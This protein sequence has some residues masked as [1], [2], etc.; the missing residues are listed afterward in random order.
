[1]RFAIVFIVVISFSLVANSA[2]I[3][4]PADYP[5]IQAGID[6]AGNTDTV[7]V[8]PGTYYENINLTGKSII[9][10]S[11]G[12][13]IDGG[14][15]GS[16]VT[17][18][19]NM[20]SVLDGFTITNGIGATHGS[21]NYAG[22]GIYCV[23]SSP[24]IK[25]NIIIG[26]S[27]GPST[28]SNGLG[29]GIYCY[30]SL[31]IITN[32]TIFNNQAAQGGGILCR[33]HI[34]PTIKNNI[35]KS[36]FA[37]YGGG[38]MCVEGC[39]AYIANNLIH[40]NMADP[41]DGGGILCN[42]SKSIIVNNTIYMNWAYEN[43][44]GIYCEAFASPSIMSNTLVWNNAIKHGG[45]I[46]CDYNC[47]ATVNNTILWD[48]YSPQG[49]TICLTNNSTLDIGHSNLEFGKTA[50]AADASSTITWGAG[51]IDKDPL[52]AD[53]SAQDFHLT[54]H[55]PC[56]DSGKNFILI[57]TV[58]FEG[59]P[60]IAFNTIDMGSDEF[61]NHLYYLGEAAPSKEISLKFVGLPGSAPVAL[62]V[63]NG[64]LNPPLPTIWGEWHLDFPLIGPI[65]FSAI[66]NDGIG[67]FTDRLPGNLIPPISIPMQTFI[68]TDLSNLCVLEV[69]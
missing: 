30:D 36:N 52:F 22:G 57:E 24:N 3:N 53:Q 65:H 19:G 17:F 47:L 63:G 68:G 49:D 9:L 14:K 54:F 50:V 59:D 20:P 21:V 31:A 16:V 23:G 27:A 2:T 6:A 67:V 13:T 7:L 25:N 45:G 18:T 33:K 56:K 58:D 8:A 44:G 4:I 48:H 29:G 69:E 26:N 11:N 43:G 15:K 41:Y 5:T 66:P 40:G 62:F 55:S 35:I 51:M 28:A 1:M 42:N 34:N 32:N 46:F 37:H 39:D 38:I 60:R 61:H 64:I 12:A 10:Q